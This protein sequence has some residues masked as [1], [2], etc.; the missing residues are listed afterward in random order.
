MAY[1]GGGKTIFEMKRKRDVDLEKKSKSHRLRDLGALDS[2]PSAREKGG[3]QKGTHNSTL[4][5]PGRIRH[6][7]LTRREF[8]SNRRGEKKTCRPNRKKR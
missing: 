8:E 6:F 3:R 4:Y 7:A 5:L 1:L 2:D